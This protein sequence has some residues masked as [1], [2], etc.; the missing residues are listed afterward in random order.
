MMNSSDYNLLTFKAISNFISELSETFGTDNHALKLYNR[1][2]DKTTITHDNAIKKHIEVFRNFCIQNREPIVGKNYKSFLNSK[3]EYSPKVFIDFNDIFKEADS[4]TANVIWKH[5]LTISALVD[6]AGKAK[7]ILKNNKESKEANFL[8]DILNKVETTVSPNSNPLEAV[9]S[10]MSS[11]LFTDLISGMNNGIQ[12]GS[13]D[14][15]KLMGTVQQMCTSIGGNM[16][17]NKMAENA[18]AANK[19]NAEAPNPMA[20]LN[21]MMSGMASMNNGTPG[22]APDLSNLSSLLGPMLSSLGAQQPPVP[23]ASLPTS[24]EE[25][26][27]EK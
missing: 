19:E 23:S 27:E 14:L 22:Q 9:S 13:L 4:E 10:I 24:I 5:L 11:G 7:E 18:N 26:R 8:S 16:D 17:I 12:D 1:L 2:L 21:S 20:M 15:S 3:V 25:V 6:P